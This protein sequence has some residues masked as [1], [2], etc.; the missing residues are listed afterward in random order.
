MSIYVNWRALRKK[1]I[2][3]DSEVNVHRV[4]LAFFDALRQCLRSL[5]DKKPGADYI[6][7]D[8]IIIISTPSDLAALTRLHTRQHVLEWQNI[9]ADTPDDSALRQRLPKVDF[10]GVPLELTLQ[11]FREVSGLIIVV[12]WDS[13]RKAGVLKT[14]KINVHLVNVT[15][16]KALRVILIDAC[17][18]DAISYTVKGKRMAI[19]RTVDIQASGRGNPSKRSA[20]PVWDSRD[21]LKVQLS[22]AQTYVASRMNDKA[23]R[24]LTQ[25]I[26]DYPKSPHVTEAKK[27][28]SKLSATP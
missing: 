9:L 8:G 11:F 26:Q 19:S 5:P 21:P 7:L 1:S 20:S 6:V 22:L 15:F 28:L 24:L 23:R 14:T 25:A 4:N 2:A 3:K 27:L 18:G 13:L 12:D 17:G 16:R 10:A